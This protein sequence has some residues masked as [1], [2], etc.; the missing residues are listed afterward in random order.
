MSPRTKSIIAIGVSLLLCSAVS[1]CSLLPEEEAELNPPLVK[2]AQENYRTITA[3][4]GILRKEISDTGSFVSVSTDIAQ[5]TGQGGRIDKIE[6][7]AG[8]TVKKGDVLVRLILDGIDL[9]LKEQELALE[10]A[11]YAYKM[12][13]ASDKEARRIASL[14]LEIEEIKYDKLKDQYSSKVITSKM[15]GQVTFTETLA[16][17]DYVE[18][19]QTLVVVSDP[20]KLR[21]TMTIGTEVDLSNVDVGSPAEVEIE[22]KV[23]PAKVVQTP[24][25]A[26]DTL[27]KDLAEKYAHT[28]YLDVPK[29]PDGTEIGSQA[30]VNIITEQ[31]DDII[32]IPKNGLRTYLGRN[33]VR[34]LEDGKRLR[35]IDVEVGVI[36]ST[37]V[38]ISK[39]LEE[40]QVIVLQ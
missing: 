34:V 33:F 35:E 5:Y 2:P 7:Q 32:K 1:G 28:L 30:I 4:R 18:P 3:E 15:D 12:T 36:G 37:E 19:Y 27:N 6:V 23:F 8:D 9:Q 17:G 21:L 40:G 22:K 31:R 29:L 24:S 11:K 13:P 14:S 16:E 26:P 20:E 10:K 39:G 38:E 25:S